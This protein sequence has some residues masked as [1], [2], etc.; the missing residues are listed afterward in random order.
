MLRAPANISTKIAI[1]LNSPLP[2]KNEERIPP[3]DCETRVLSIV[4]C[5]PARA[6]TCSG[7]RILGLHKSLPSCCASAKISVANKELHRCLLEVLDESVF[8]L[9]ICLLRAGPWCIAGWFFFGERA[10]ALHTYAGKP[11]GAGLV[12]G[13]EIWLVYSLGRVQRAG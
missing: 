9:T 8:S 4:R 13:R 7:K 10:T 3:L 12:P 11:E 2:S 1:L 6:T 5:R